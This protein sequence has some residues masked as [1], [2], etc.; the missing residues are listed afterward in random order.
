MPYLHQIFNKK[1]LTDVID[2]YN[3]FYCEFRILEKNTVDLF[4]YVTL[5]F[6]HIALYQ[7]RNSHIFNV[8]FVKYC[9]NV[10]DSLRKC[11]ECNGNY[12]KKP[13]WDFPKV[14]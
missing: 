6:H 2:K 13:F 8:Y 10:L 5:T 11:G 14:L 9:C 1:C 7:L 4:P 12:L 3:I